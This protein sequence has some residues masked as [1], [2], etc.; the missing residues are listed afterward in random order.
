VLKVTV[1]AYWEEDE[2]TDLKAFTTPEVALAYCIP[3]VAAKVGYSLT[4]DD[5][6]DWDVLNT[7][8]EHPGCS[9]RLEYDLNV[10]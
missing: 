8:V 9:W 5:N 3:F 7:Q 4:G 1:F 6:V 2:L 10:E